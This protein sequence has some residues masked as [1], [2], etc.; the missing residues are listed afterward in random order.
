MKTAIMLALLITLVVPNPPQG[1]RLDATI[2]RYDRIAIQR[3][4]NTLPAR[5]RVNIPLVLVSMPTDYDGGETCGYYDDQPPQRIVL[6]HSCFAGG[7][8]RHEFAHHLWST[9][10]NDYERNGWKRI[11][12]LLWSKMPN[13][14]AQTDSEEGWA[15]CWDALYSRLP[16]D[17]LIR[18]EISQYRVQRIQP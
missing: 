18:R 12:K 13:S 16:L 17:P 11:W 3:F 2:Q 9:V 6:H 4:S 10:L 14:N 7:V 8:F 15:E 1:V 5:Y